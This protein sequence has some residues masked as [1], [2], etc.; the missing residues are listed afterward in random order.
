[1]LCDAS[2]KNFTSYSVYNFFTVMQC[3]T[4]YAK[5]CFGCTEKLIDSLFSLPYICRS[6]CLYTAVEC[7]DIVHELSLIIFL[8][9]IVFWQPFSALMLL[10]GQ[11]EE[12][13]ALKNSS[14]EVLAWLSGG[15]E[16]QLTCIWL[17]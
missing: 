2:F 8:C 3:D 6:K 15:S 7:H 11:Q 9:G 1:M 12:H 5:R 13:P 17:S 16:V 10:V 4:I 14:N